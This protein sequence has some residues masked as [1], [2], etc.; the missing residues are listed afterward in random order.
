M[1][2][3]FSRHR[4]RRWRN[5]L[6]GIL[7]PLLV[8]VWT[9]T[10]RV[11]YIADLPHTDGLPSIPPG[12]FVLWHQRLFTLGGCLRNAQFLALVSG[13]ADGEMLARLLSGLGFRP[14]RGS[15]T[16]GGT[17][18][19][20]ELLHASERGLRVAIT[21]DG[22]RG[23]R[24]FVQPGPVYL[25]SRSG[26]V[27]YPVTASFA[28]AWSLSTWDEFKLPRPFTRTLLRL[29]DPHQVPPDLDREAIE[30]WRLRI[31]RS[32]RQ[33]TEDTDL[34]FDALYREARRFR[35][36]SLQIDT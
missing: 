17:R 20:L 7:G 11:R 3:I 25:S 12:I 10:L 2:R 34:R 33:L 31:E 22:P 35:G 14:V 30:A 18:A 28:K 21:P 8:R 15:S 4:R 9:G 6:V 19:I 36:F 29:G 26:L 5:R 23:P 16:R 1:G 27:V 13:H 32:L 24:F